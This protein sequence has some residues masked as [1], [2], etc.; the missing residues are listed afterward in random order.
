[1]HWTGFFGESFILK[2]HSCVV[3]VTHN[4]WF[5][6]IKLELGFPMF[7]T[8]HLPTLKNTFPSIT[9]FIHAVAIQSWSFL[10][11]H[12]Y[13]G[14]ITHTLQFI[15]QISQEYLVQHKLLQRSLQSLIS[16]E[17]PLPSA[18]PNHL[19]LPFACYVCNH[20]FTQVRSNLLHPIIP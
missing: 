5:V 13:L 14:I 8:I 18:K 4:S 19:L 17:Q 11:L 20:H 12:E 2:S 6:Y 7:I 10:F 1:M 16:P 3:Q 15:T 9:C